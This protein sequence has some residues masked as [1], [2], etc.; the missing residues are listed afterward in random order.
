[1]KIDLRAA[2]D[3]LPMSGGSTGPVTEMMVGRKGG[4]PASGTGLYWAEL[5]ERRRPMKRSLIAVALLSMLCG[6]TQAKAGT[7]TVRLGH[8]LAVDSAIGIVG[9]DI[10]RLV[11]E[12]TQGALKIDVLPGA[13]LGKDRDMIESLQLGSVEMNIQGDIL[14]SIVVPEWGQVLTTPFVIRDKM[15]FRQVVDG[16]LTRPMYEAMLE[17]KGIRNLG[18]ID[19]GP[20]YMT[21]NKPIREPAELKGLKIRVPEVETYVAAWKLL[22]ATVTPMDFSELFLALRQGTVDAQENPLEVIYNQSLY[23]VQKFLNQTAHLYTGFEVLVSERWFRT[24]SPELQKIVNEAAAEAIAIG[25]KAQA[26]SE[27]EYERKLKEK[28]MIFNPVDRAKFEDVLKDLPKQFANKWKP[29]FY[30]AV[31]A[32]K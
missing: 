18:W 5:T 4:N 11:N 24:L 14:I 32:V 17:R 12:R 21:S 6:V 27:V 23:E 28:G 13:Q 19:R 10:A 31:K 16:P 7:T 3:A 29:G 15:H 9:K 25:N 20:R 26:S 8:G 2:C 1:M 30:E 22:G